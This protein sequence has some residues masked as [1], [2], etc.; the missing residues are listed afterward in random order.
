MSGTNPHIICFSCVGVNVSIRC[1]NMPF[2]ELLRRNFEAMKST[3]SSFHKLEYQ[4]QSRPEQHGYTVARRDSGFDCLVDKTDELIYLLE[5]DL[6]VQLQLLRADLLFLHSA[7]VS[8]DDEAHLLIGRSGAGKSTTCWGLLHHGF[9]Y[10]SDE[11]APIEISEGL[12]APYSH[13][14]CMKSPPPAEYPIPDATCATGRGY[15]IPLSAMPTVA[16]TADLPLRTIFFVDYQSGNATSTVTPIRH[17]EA[18]ARL[19][20]NILNAL[21]HQNEGLDAARR[22]TEHV[23]CFRVNAGLLRSTCDM[24]GR[25]VRKRD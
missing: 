6:V 2:V 15:H 23:R 1:D 14:L 17:A 21:A 4:I 25:I 8:F 9:H 20:P 24:I 22:L 7:V 19:Y 12:V 5:G 10:V 18:A 11:L 16:I 13:A 3:V